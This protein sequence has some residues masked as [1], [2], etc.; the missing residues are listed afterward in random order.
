MLDVIHSNPEVK[1]KCW[2]CGESHMVAKSGYESSYDI[3]ISLDCPEC[4]ATAELK[5]SKITNV[6]SW[7]QW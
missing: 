3:D 4:G 2:K 6:F 1:I 7:K 5:I